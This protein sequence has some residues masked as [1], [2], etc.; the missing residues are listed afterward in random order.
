MVQR[1]D[2]S[3]FLLQSENHP[4]IDVRSPA[5][6]HQAHIPGAISLPLFSDEERAVVGT[7]YKQSGREEAM[8]KG[9]QFYGKNMQE[10]INQLKDQTSDKQLFVHCWRGGMRSEV[11]AWMLGLFGYNASVLNKGYK[12]FRRKVLDSFSESR[13]MLILGGK[14]GS[15]KT[16]I[17]NLLRKRGEQVI[18]LEALA[19]HRGSAFGDILDS[20]QSPSQEQFENDLFMQ[21]RKTEPDK[22]IWLEDESQR[23]GQIN[24]P[25][26]IWQQMRT[27]KVVYVE[28][29]FE[30]RLQYIVT[31]YGKSDVNDLKASTIRIQKRLGGLDTKNAIQ[32]LESGDIKNAFAI[33]LRY[34]DKCYE[35]AT[36]NRSPEKIERLYFDQIDPSAIA[37]AIAS[38]LSILVS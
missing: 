7:L 13:K 26:S 21:F 12:G 17:L 33:F 29:P 35:R 1:L 38:H 31:H 27:A 3:S 9:L 20:S 14:S 30:Q 34:Y 37:G 6:Y 15:A 11:V 4:V 5:E 36:T 16:E 22:A 2:I 8:M 23:I 10:I 24:L 32:F 25:N 18:D 28:I 19:H